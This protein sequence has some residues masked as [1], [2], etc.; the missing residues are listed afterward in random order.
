MRR[1]EELSQKRRRRRENGDIASTRG[2]IATREGS[3]CE[4]H[5]VEVCLTNEPRDADNLVRRMCVRLAG[6]ATH[7]GMSKVK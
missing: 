2:E 3:R 7:V 6:R 1:D 5:F 4:A